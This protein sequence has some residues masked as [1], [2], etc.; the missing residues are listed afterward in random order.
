[1]TTD[2]NEAPLKRLDFNATGQQ[3]ASA[4]NVTI[5][6]ASAI[7][8]NDHVRTTYGTL[9]VI[10]AHSEGVSV[11]LHMEMPDGDTLI[12]HAMPDKEFEVLGEGSNE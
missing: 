3:V 5:T 4:Q 7:R 8:V 2:R 6:P 1:M 11:C 12:Y 9:P 10:F